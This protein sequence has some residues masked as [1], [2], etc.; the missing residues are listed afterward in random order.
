MTQIVPYKPRYPIFRKSKNAVLVLNLFPGLGNLYAQGMRGF[1]WLAAAGAA[2]YFIP[3][4]V[5]WLIAYAAVSAKGYKAAERHNALVE[6]GLVPDH[7]KAEF[8]NLTR[9]H[10]KHMLEEAS[11]ALGP[12]MT[13][14]S[15][16][17]TF[18]S[19]LEGLQSR[20][21]GTIRVFEKKVNE[22]LL[23]EKTPKAP[24]A[25][26]EGQAPQANRDYIA[27]Q[28]NPDYIAPQANPDYIAPQALEPAP[29]PM[30]APLPPPFPSTLTEP[31]QSEEVFQPQ[32][33][34]SQPEPALSQP[35]PALLQ[36]STG[37]TPPAAPDMVQQKGSLKGQ[38]FC[39]ECGVERDPN[40]TFCLACGAGTIP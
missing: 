37:E 31:A 32:A 21:E 2:L 11:E 24:P 4:I 34:L 13:E 27:A 9:D 7:L 36:P 29:H 18:I 5:T 12:K 39:I 1:I 6:E 38:K 33:A 35:E 30:P 3:H 25:Q 10:V 40:F 17:V 14:Y 28:A 22:I 15:V 23:G 19:I 16:L 26:M 20:L 8:G